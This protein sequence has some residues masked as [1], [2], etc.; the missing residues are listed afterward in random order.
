M[1]MPEDHWEQQRQE[2]AMAKWWDSHEL[3]HR[4]E[5]VAG[6]SYHEEQARSEMKEEISSRVIDRM[7][8][9]GVAAGLVVGVGVYV[10]VLSLLY[11]FDDAIPTL[12]GMLLILGG[13]FLIPL[14]GSVV[15]GSFGGWC[16]RRLVRPRR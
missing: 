4:E 5:V 14:G 2:L 1:M 16:G 9:V 11:R 3:R 7:E 13:F 8:W 6:V 10:L 12:V 15:I